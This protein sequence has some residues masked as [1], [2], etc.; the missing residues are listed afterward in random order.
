MSNFVKKRCAG[1]PLLKCTPSQGQGEFFVFDKKGMKKL[2]VGFR[3]W[4]AE[5][6]LTSHEIPVIFSGSQA[7]E[8]PLISLVIVIVG[9]GADRLV[10]LLKAGTGGQIDLIL[11]MAEEALLGRVVPAVGATGHGL[12]EPAVLHQLDK[13]HAGVMGALVAVDQDL[14]L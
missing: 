14:G 8:I 13:L 11:Y 4:D 6:I 9:P 1:V 5:R 12:A 2:S 10:D 7:G 3:R